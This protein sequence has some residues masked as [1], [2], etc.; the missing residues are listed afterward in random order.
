MNEGTN[1]FLRLEKGRV[2]GFKEGD[3]IPL[4]TDLV[5][6]GRP[7]R[8]AGS[9]VE[10]P[11]IKIADDYVSRGHI[12]IYYSHD[13]GCFMLQE[14]EGGTPGGTFIAGKQVQP[15]IPNPLV[16]GDL[17]GLAK[18]GE[19]HR[20]VFRF[21]TGEGTLLGFAG[22]E[23]QAAKGLAVDLVARIVW[24]D[25]KE[26][27]LRKKEYDLLAFLYQNKGKACSKDLIAEKV[28]VEEEGIVSQETID[29]NIHRIRQGI[30]ADLASPRY[31]KT[32]RGYGY[33]LDL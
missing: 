17:I 1:N 4:G 19:E 24:L 32:L 31:I 21:R 28:W 14:R 30:E 9:D 25:G 22:P 23:K 6:I 27:Y 2:E 33:R 29:Q 13:K 15:G 5:L 26:V 3:E 16:D 20:V 18:I 11:D 12:K 7:P 8:R 10:I